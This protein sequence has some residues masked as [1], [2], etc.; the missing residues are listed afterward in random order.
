MDRHLH[1]DLKGRMR[2]S[3]RRYLRSLSSRSCKYC[4]ALIVQQ[5]LACGIHTPPFS[6][7]VTE[8][9]SHSKVL[10]STMACRHFTMISTERVPR[11]SPH[12]VGGR[13]PYNHLRTFFGSIKPQYP[14]TLCCCRKASCPHAGMYKCEMSDDKHVI[15]GAGAMY[16]IAFHRRNGAR[17]ST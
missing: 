16:S 4:R 8:A 13:D 10:S 3:T 11:S 9:K 14:Q 2:T 1:L 12:S 17:S 6:R 15:P 7:E 5:H